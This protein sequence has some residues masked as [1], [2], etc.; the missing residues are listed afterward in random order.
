MKSHDAKDGVGGQQVDGQI[1]EQSPGGHLR[2]MKG[3]NKPDQ[4]VAGVGNPGES[5]HPLDV[6]LAKGGQV[7]KENGDRRNGTKKWAYKFLLACKGA[8]E[9]LEEDQYPGGF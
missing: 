9:Q 7:S 3:G 1:E 6:A 5:H 2:N 4:Q 8:G